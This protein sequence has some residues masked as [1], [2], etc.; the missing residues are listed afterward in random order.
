MKEHESNSII[1]RAKG[2]VFQSKS[3][4]SKLE[5]T[6][7]SDFVFGEMIELSKKYQ[8]IKSILKEI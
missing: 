5:S 7:F 3:S 1:F 8:Q 4:I 6:E 2:T